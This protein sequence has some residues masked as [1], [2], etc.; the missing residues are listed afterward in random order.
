MCLRLVDEIDSQYM[1]VTRSRCGRVSHIKRFSQSG[2]IFLD[3]ISLLYY[4][5]P[6]SLSPSLDI[7]NHAQSDQSTPLLNSSQSDSRASF[8]LLQ[9]SPSM[10]PFFPLSSKI[11]RIAAL[12]ENLSPRLSWVSTSTFVEA[13]R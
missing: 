8:S 2:V 4:P 9:H 13:L 10:W 7:L 5:A 1:K 6:Y 11:T 3:V 12:H